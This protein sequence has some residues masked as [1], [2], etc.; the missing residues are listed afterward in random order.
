VNGQG[1]KRGKGGAPAPRGGGGEGAG[2]EQQKSSRKVQ[3]SA[4]DSSEL[5]API[6]ASHSIY[7][8]LL[9]YEE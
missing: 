7:C 9:L 2:N 8:Q 6:I 4:M 5:Y 3:T 1:G